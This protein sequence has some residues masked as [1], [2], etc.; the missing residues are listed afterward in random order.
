MNA[1]TTPTDAQA[2]HLANARTMLIRLQAYTAKLE[3]DPAADRPLTQQAWL[4]V[5]DAGVS[6]TDDGDFMDARDTAREEMGIDCDG[7][8]IGAAREFD[9]S[10]VHPDNPSQDAGW[11]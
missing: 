10:L 8:P 9:P 11:S 5:C 3:R 7:L 2:I 6:L 1:Q 4:E